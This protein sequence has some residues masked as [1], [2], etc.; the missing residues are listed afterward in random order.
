MVPK[1]LSG[2]VTVKLVRKDGSELSTEKKILSDASGTLV[3]ELDEHLTAQ[4]ALKISETSEGNMYKLFFVIT[5]IVEGVGQCE[6]TIV[7]RP[8]IVYS[9]KRKHTK[10]KPIVLAC[11]PEEGPHSRPNEVWIKG[12]GFGERISVMFGDQPAEVIENNEHLLVVK[13]PA[14]PSIMEDTQVSVVIANKFM[15]TLLSAENSLL[16]TYRFNPNSSSDRN[17]NNNN[18]SNSS[19][20]EDNENNNKTRK[21]TLIKKEKGK[22]KGRETVEEPDD[23]EEDDDEIESV[24]M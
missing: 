5:F 9:H 4:F 17:N 15:Q 14:L 21:K 3:R 13:A 6:E 12:S 1:I 11:K 8:F 18:N 16:Y 7:S 2:R 23:D 19:S 10:E 20:K 24:N 22:A